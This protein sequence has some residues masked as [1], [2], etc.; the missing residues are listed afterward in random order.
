M[1]GLTYACISP[2]ITCLCACFFLVY[3]LVWRYNFLYVYQRSM[4]SSDLFQQTARLILASL[5]LGLILT[6]CMLLNR[7]ADWPA[8]A[9][10][11][12]GIFLLARSAL[13]LEQRKVGRDLA[14][15]IS[16]RAP[17]GAINTGERYIHPALRPDAKGWHPNIKVWRFFPPCAKSAW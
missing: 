8:A 7:G 17:A 4:V 1:V 5:L 10:F 14:L 15:S 12:A 2:I 13:S 9:L 6:A 3:L 16:A 11:T